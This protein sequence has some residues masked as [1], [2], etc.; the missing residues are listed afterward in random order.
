MTYL[1]LI[2]LLK[3]QTLLLLFSENK[4]VNLRLIFVVSFAHK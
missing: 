1:R 3:R 2:N 4:L